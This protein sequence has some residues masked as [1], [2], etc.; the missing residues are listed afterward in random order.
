MPTTMDVPNFE[1]HHVETFADT[2]PDVNQGGQQGGMIVA[3][4]CITNAIKDSSPRWASRC[5]S[6]TYRRPESSS[7]SGRCRNEG[8]GVQ[9]H[10]PR[11][12][13]KSSR[14]SPSW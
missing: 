10:S 7:S 11:S 9:Y 2:S 1:I 14:C 5:V 6:S 13:E 8:G 12:V 3:P 4:A